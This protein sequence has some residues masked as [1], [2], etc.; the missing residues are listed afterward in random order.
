MVIQ[1]SE[2]RCGNATPKFDGFFV[3]G[4]DKPSLIGV[5]LGHRSFPGGIF[6]LGVLQGMTIRICILRCCTLPPIIMEV[7]NGPSNS[8][9][10]SNIAI[11]H[12]HDCGRK[13]I[14]FYLVGL[15]VLPPMNENIL[16]QVELGIK[17][18]F[19]SVKIKHFQVNPSF[20]PPPCPRNNPYTKRL[21]CVAILLEYFRL[22]LW[23]TSPIT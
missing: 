18:T 15:F 9:Y 22:S 1:R 12:L 3:R 6:C 5:A 19:S 14:G 23:N 2:S 11:F 4:H 21:A 13:S 10:L 16:V 8:S 7:K 17:S 20:V